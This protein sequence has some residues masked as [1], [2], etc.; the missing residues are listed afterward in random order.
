MLRIGSDFELLQDSPA[1]KLKAL[2][3]SAFSNLFGSK[4][5]ASLLHRR[6]GFFLLLLDRFALPSTGHI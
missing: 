3:F 2:A 1:G 5:L 4:R 6:C